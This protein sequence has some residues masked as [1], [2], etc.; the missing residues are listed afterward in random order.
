MKRYENH[1]LHI[2][3]TNNICNWQDLENQ[4]CTLEPHIAGKVFEAFCYY[5]YLTEPTV[6]DDFMQ[7]YYMEDTPDDLKLT[8][9]IT[10]D[11]GID[12]ILKSH[13]NALTAIQCKFTSNVERTLTWGG[14]KLSHFIGYSE[15]ADE[16]V[17]F[18][19][20]FDVDKVTRS[21]DRVSVINNSFLQEIEE[22]TFDHI[23]SLLQGNNTVEHTKAQPWEFQIDAI[24]S[25][26][27]RFETENRGQLI[28][29]CGTGKTLVG[30]KIKEAIKA[31]STLVA[32]PSLWLLRQTK[33]YWAKEKDVDHNYKYLCVCSEYD[34]DN[35]A[36]LDNY[37]IHDYDVDHRVTT[38]IERLRN[39]LL[40]EPS[41][42]I[43]TTFHSLHTIAKAIKDTDFQFD[44]IFC[45]EAHRT[46]GLDNKQSYGVIHNNNEIPARKRL[47][48]TAT[49]RV[50]SSYLKKKNEDNDDVFLY[51]M[52][53]KNVFG[54][55]FFRMSF[56]TAIESKRLVDYQI[57]AVG[58]N[59]SQIA[60]YLTAKN[61]GTEIADNYALEWVMDK[62]GATH[63]ISF[64]STIPK[65]KVFA[66]K[67]NEK[68]KETTKTFHIN[69]THTTSNR[70]RTLMAFKAADKSIISNVR[71]LSEGVDVPAIDAVYFC[72]PKSSKIDIAQSVGRA[73]RLDPTKNKEF[74]Y[75]VVPIYHQ[76]HEEIETVVKKSIF[77]NLINVVRSMY[78][79]DER[80]QDEIHTLLYG[81]KGSNGLSRTN[82]LGV[83]TGFERIVLVGF[84]D[85]LKE[86]L[87][88]EI[89]SK[90]TRW[91]GWYYLLMEW[92]KENDGSSNPSYREVYKG[93]KLGEWIMRQRKLC[94]RGALS[95][96][97]VELL[98]KI[99]F[100]WKLETIGNGRED[101]LTRDLQKLE[102]Y[103]KIHN[104]TDVPTRE[105][106]NEDQKR[107]WSV[108]L[109]SFVNRRLR[110][111]KLWP[112][113]NGNDN[114]IFN[115]QGKDLPVY[116]FLEMVKFKK[117]PKPKH[118]KII[119]DRLREEREKN[120]N[121]GQSDF[122]QLFRRD[123]KFFT[124]VRGV[125]TWYKDYLAKD[126]QALSYF[127][128]GEIETLNSLGFTW[129]YN[130][131]EV[132]IKRF[133]GLIAYKK[134]KGTFKV[135]PF[136]DQG[137]HAWCKR[138]IAST[139]ER[140]SIRQL[141]EAEGISVAWINELRELGFNVD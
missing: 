39:F 64:H 86:S 128:D 51:D 20:A 43:F 82:F 106:K 104:H 2:F 34:I 5:Y 123:R 23:K 49:P 79:Q 78:D 27:T 25:C 133:E 28:M 134:K 52:N 90:T 121:F 101:T 42:V 1:L 53:D 96:K 55:E 139:K 3:M 15:Q 107:G 105:P 21:R 88:D 63:A 60:K 118:V 84:E 11:N 61:F 9:N 4:L 35:D 113:I 140:F 99:N 103:F 100:N 116:K 74:G 71:C 97:Y 75:I 114:K 66:E 38:D 108:G 45:D 132:E 12:L 29:P 112:V 122:E 65:A 109:A 81:Q 137:L 69:G 131:D 138:R 85:K 8:L 124:E 54:E 41:T 37:S 110:T 62:Y 18:T 7:V 91:D 24:S 136:D 93:K 17:V 26:A 87:F 10:S 95:A 32:V 119:I 94:K 36:K 59:D 72:D 58:V 129:G 76:K 127:D 141:I 13:D 98:N 31:K 111:P 126:K 130:L 77:N 57:I 47:Y 56:K 83:Q 68:F 135:R 19:N 14:D 89:L 102:A 117:D 22:E 46:T 70:K 120:P 30:L 73:L 125:R 6:K 80:L 48:S 115:Y 16:R 67:H 92:A 40:T 50:L 44:F 33:N